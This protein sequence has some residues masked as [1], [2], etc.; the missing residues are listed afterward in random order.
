[1]LRVNIVAYEKPYKP[2]QRKSRDFKTLYSFLPE[3]S[4]KLGCHAGVI[5]VTLSL[6]H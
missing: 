6:T 1:M 4:K 2:L 5:Q 3:D